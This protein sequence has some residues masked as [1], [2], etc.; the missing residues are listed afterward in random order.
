MESV[1]QF[2]SN[3]L[4]PN[5]Y[6]EIIDEWMRKWLSLKNQEIIIRPYLMEI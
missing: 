6:T 1:N 4:F 5:Y 2:E 3:G